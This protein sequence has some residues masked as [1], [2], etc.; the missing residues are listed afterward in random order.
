[1]KNI[2]IIAALAVCDLLLAKMDI[3]SKKDKPLTSKITENK[4]NDN[5]E[6]GR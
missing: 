4:I 1:M 5:A 3:F 2:I 6:N